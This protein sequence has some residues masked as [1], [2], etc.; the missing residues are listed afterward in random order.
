MFL[1]ICRGIGNQFKEMPGTVFRTVKSVD[2][3][4][5]G[6]PRHDK[7]TKYQGADLE[8][9]SYFLYDFTDGITRFLIALNQLMHI[10]LAG[11]SLGNSL[12]YGCPMALQGR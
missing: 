4:S 8:P 10:E 5:C 1:V 7:P 11:G 2:V 9:C 12:T 6:N 3:L